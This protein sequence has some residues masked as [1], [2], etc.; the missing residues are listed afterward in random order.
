MPRSR[1][2]VILPFLVLWTLPSCESLDAGGGPGFLDELVAPLTVDH[3]AVVT[4]QADWNE[5]LSNLPLYAG[6]RLRVDF[7]EARLPYCRATYNGLATYSI[8]LYW[9]ALPDTTVRQVVLRKVGGIGRTVLDVPEAAQDLEIWFVNTDRQGCRAVDS[10]LEA[11]YHFP[12]TPPAARTDVVFGSDWTE[13]AAGTLVQGGLMRI[14]YAPGRLGACRATYAGGR[15]WNIVASWRFLPGGQNGTVAMYGGDYYAGEAAILQPEVGIPADATGVELWFGN[16]DRAG[17]VAWD[18]DFGMNYRFDVAPAGGEHPSVGWAGDFDFVSF[19][20]D[21]AWHQGDVDPAYYFDSMGGSETVTYVEVQAWIPGITDKPYPSREAAK[22]AADAGVMAQAVTD[23]RAGAVGGWG[24]IP[25]GFERQQGN[26]FVYSFRFWTLRS[27]LQPD[28]PIAAGLYRWY[29]RFS[30]DGGISWHEAGKEGDRTRR[31]VVAPRQDCTLFPDHPPQGCPVDRAV[32]WAGNLGRY[33]THACTWQAGLADPVVFAKSSVGHDCMTLTAE[34]YVAGLTDANGDPAALKA[35]VETDI[36][37]QGGPMAGPVTYALA[38]DAR[39]GNNF[40][41]AWGL[42][43]HVGRVDR[44]EYR[45]RFRFSADNGG[46]WYV[47][48]QGDGPADATW[49]ALHV[50]ND[51]LDVDPVA[52]CEGVEQWDGA[53]NVFPACLEAANG[54]DYAAANCEFYVNAL[55]RGQMSHNGAS[56][57]WFETYVK[58]GAQEGEVLN[59]GQWTRYVEAG[60]TKEAWSLGRILEPGYWMTGFTSART[61]PGGNSFTREVGDFAFFIDVRRPAGEVVRLWQSNGGANYT[62]AAEFATPG[63]R[64]SIGVGDIEYVVESANVLGQKRACVD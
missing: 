47:V 15:A 7:A 13:T 60:V 45:F 56:A 18:S 51:S 50:R 17:C 6:G 46:S 55:G 37:F 64:K 8:T 44:G 32:G 22:A 62:E 19:H 12:V 27:A 43:E 33:A 3:E 1:A 11:N 38:Y 53:T 24:T 52:V 40:R 39:V 29:V 49:R 20:R 31:F 36:G 58:V 42:G 30:A 26:N 14:V 61:V 25:L 57:R 9:R 2:I 16:S 5:V 21:P 59:V 23:A 28:P 10:N 4:F 48:G 35:E 54:G 63:Y 34:V 41:F